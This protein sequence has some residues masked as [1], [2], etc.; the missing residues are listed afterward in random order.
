VPFTELGKAIECYAARRAAG[1]ATPEDLAERALLG[2]EM[3]C[4][5]YNYLEAMQIVFRFTAD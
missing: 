1:R 2:E 3:G 4:E 5:G